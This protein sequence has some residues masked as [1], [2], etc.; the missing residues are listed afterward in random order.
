MSLSP[1]LPDT[2]SIFSG[3]RVGSA[4]LGTQMGLE[5]SLSDL[6]NTSP[7]PATSRA[8]DLLGHQISPRH[9]VPGMCTFPLSRPE[10]IRKLL[11]TP[12]AI[13]APVGASCPESV[14]YA[15]QG[16]S[17]AN[18]FSSPAA[19]TAP[20]GPMNA[21]LQGGR[22]QLSPSL[23]CLQAAFR[24]HTVSSAVRSWIWFW[25]SLSQLA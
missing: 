24:V 22:V 17:W 1:S 3:G 4:S 23:I 21:S 2:N 16:P 8:R 6:S 14:L 12:Y 19:H 25:W 9:T 7:P 15:T 10:S 11:A 5:G 20:S 18:V 13:I